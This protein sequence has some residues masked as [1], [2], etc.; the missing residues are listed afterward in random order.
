MDQTRWEVNIAAANG[1]PVNPKKKSNQI[2]ED[3]LEGNAQ[4][5]NEL[6]LIVTECI[7][8]SVNK[9]PW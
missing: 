2:G 3:S 6:N 1:Q 9:M 4:N 8:G 5:L 7:F